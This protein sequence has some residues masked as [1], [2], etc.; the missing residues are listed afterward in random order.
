MITQISNFPRAPSFEVIGLV[1]DLKDYRVLDEKLVGFAGEM[2][3]DLVSAYGRRRLEAVR[4]GARLE[5]Q[6][7]K[8]YRRSP[9]EL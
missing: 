3:I 8:R 2:N 6:G 9:S 4:D 1:G 5:D 7:V